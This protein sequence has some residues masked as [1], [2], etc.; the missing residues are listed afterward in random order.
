[1]ATAFA[2]TSDLA[3]RLGQAVPT[4]TTLARWQ[5]ALSDASTYLRSVIGAQVWPASTTTAVLFGDG[6]PWLRLPGAAVSVSSVTG[7]VVPSTYELIDGA[8]YSESG[9]VGKLT[10]EYEVGLESAPD[11][12][13]A[14]ACVVASQL[15]TAVDDLGSMSAAGVSAVAIDDYRKSWSQGE[16]GI[17]LPPRVVDMLRASYGTGAFVT[18]VR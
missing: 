6:G 1:M 12:L 15:L 10:V 3:A 2:T 7:T 5:A 13:V 9:W 8:L 18:G 14:W 4:G 17:E 11:D 16:S